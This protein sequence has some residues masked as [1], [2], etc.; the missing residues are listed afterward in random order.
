M[1]N[2]GCGFLELDLLRCWQLRRDAAVVRVAA[3][4]QR[5]I[6]ALAVRG[7]CLRHYLAG[8]L[9]PEFPDAK[10]LESVRVTVHLIS[11]QIPGLLVKSGSLL[12]LD[13]R[14]DVDLHRVRILLMESAAAVNGK[15]GAV[16]RNLRDAELLPGWYEDWVLSE[17]GRL[18]HDLLRA[19]TAFARELASQ[20]DCEGAAD[21]AL[22]A[23]DIEPLYE[24]AVRA[25]VH[26]EFKL[27]NT[28][29]AMAAY[30]KYK[31][32]LLDDIGVLPSEDL[33]NLING[34]QEPG[35]AEAAAVL[36][37]PGGGV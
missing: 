25:L 2:D 35:G 7:P 6:A 33:R 23:L 14:V 36:S 15:A 31:T 18:R 5:L 4:Q 20:G 27:G 9:W 22:A 10:A 29:A 34:V 26:A 1:G 21:A 12:A 13:P 28:A 17:Q 16:L 24:S 32:K 3:R 11:R 19:F 8:L 30:E 37:S